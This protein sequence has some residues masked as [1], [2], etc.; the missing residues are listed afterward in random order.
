MTFGYWNNQPIVLGFLLSVVNLCLG[1]VTPPLFLHF[2]AR[3]GASELQN[4]DGILR[5]QKFATRLDIVWRLVIGFLL[6]LPL[7][8]SVAYKDL[9]ATR[10]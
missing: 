10:V 8:L 1:S 9:Q 2:E 3:S 5:N 7:G 6:V 4:Y